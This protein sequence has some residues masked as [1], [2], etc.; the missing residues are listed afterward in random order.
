MREDSQRRKDRNFYPRPPR[1]GRRLHAPSFRR[2]YRISIHALREEGD[3]RRQH[4]SLPICDFYPRP[5]RGGRPSAFL[6]VVQGVE[7]LSTPS[8]RRA[9]GSA[10][11]QTSRPYFYPRPPR[12][13]RPYAGT[14]YHLLVDFYPRPPRGGRPAARAKRNGRKFLST[15][16]ARRATCEKILSGESRNFYP[17]PPRGGRR[18]HAPS[19]RRC[20]RI[21][22]HAL[23]EE[24]DLRRQ[25]PVPS[26]MRFLSTPSARRATV[27]VSSGRPGCRISIHALREEGDGFLPKCRQ[28]DHIS[29]HAL[30]EEGDLCRTPYHLFGRFLSTPSARRATGTGSVLAVAV[31]ISIHA[32][33]EEGDVQ[34]LTADLPN[35]FLSTPSARRA[36]SAFPPVVQ[37]VE[38]LSTPSARRAT[39]FLPLQTVDHISIHALREEGDGKGLPPVYAF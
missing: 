35:R 4:Q 36:T 15:P 8:A 29:I 25:H 32:L 17:R 21:S 39:G 2:C 30:R 14:P 26:H 20:Y 37:R 13:G 27:S 18:L 28:A 34:Q 3:L 31:I 16:S 33:R 5:P 6:R 1:G 10:K 22:I 11:M 7:F 38:F 24:G 19:F 23:R 9:T 12:G